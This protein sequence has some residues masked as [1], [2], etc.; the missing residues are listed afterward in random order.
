MKLAL[1]S[2]A[3]IAAP[4]FAADAPKAATPKAE[5]PKAEAK[6][7]PAAAPKEP[8]KTDDERAIYTIGF[9]MG[10]NVSAFNMSPAE[11]KIIQAGLGDAIL[12]A[13]PKVDVRFYQPRV[14]EVLSKRLEGAAVKEKE[15]GRA[16]TEKFVKENKPQAIPG[17]GW[18]LETLAG[19]GAIPA[20]TDTI[21]AHYRGTTTD[22]AEFDSSY[23]R[24]APTEFSLTA[25]IPCWTN[26]ISMMKVGGK[27]KLVC[28]SD[29]AYGDQGRSG[30]K[31]GATLIFEVELV[32]IVKPEA[33]KK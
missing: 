32:E 14:N 25:V 19:T 17:G 23:S 7:A 20:K 15:K 4:A 13:P 24:G 8:Y 31:G 12:G 22:G 29:V 16:F 30:I 33:L 5:A 9:L 28:P 11:A 10:K 21:K 3:L 27:A 18:Y 26:G 2:L 6:K 1:L